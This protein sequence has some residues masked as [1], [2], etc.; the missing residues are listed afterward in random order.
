MALAQA[1]S[2]REKALLAQEGVAISTYAKGEEDNT[3]TDDTS[4]DQD[5]DEVR[6][7]VS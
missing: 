2:A 7:E 4:A 3:N 5:A 1:N 6:L